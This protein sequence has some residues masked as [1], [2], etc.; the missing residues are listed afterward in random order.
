MEKQCI[1][2]GI[3]YESE[4]TAV[5]AVGITESGMMWTARWSHLTRCGGR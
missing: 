3:R 2:N 5:K 1:T 4:D